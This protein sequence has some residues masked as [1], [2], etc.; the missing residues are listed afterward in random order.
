MAEREELF[1]FDDFLLNKQARTLDRL[2]PD[3]RTVPIQIGSRALQ[4]L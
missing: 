4:I 1:R 3:G 2:L